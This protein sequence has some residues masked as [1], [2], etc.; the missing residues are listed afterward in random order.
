MFFRGKTADRTLAE[1]AEQIASIEK[2]LTRIERRW[3]PGDQ[4]GLDA[5]LA[6][7][8]RAVARE[9]EQ[10]TRTPEKATLAA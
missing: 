2:R 5:A 4:R 3:A 7:L 9:E 6:D 10:K 8:G 1:L